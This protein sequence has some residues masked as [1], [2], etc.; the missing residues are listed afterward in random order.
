[1]CSR[2]TWRTSRDRYLALLEFCSGSPYRALTLWL[3]QR[4]MRRA[5]AI[6]NKKMEENI[7]LLRSCRG[8]T[9][10]LLGECNA[11]RLKDTTNSAKRWYVS[12]RLHD[13]T[14]QKTIRM[15]SLVRTVQWT[16]CVLNTVTVRLL[17]CDVSN[18]WNIYSVW[19]K[20]SVLLRGCPVH[21]TKN[22]CA[23]GCLDASIFIY[24]PFCFRRT[25]H[26]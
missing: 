23:L 13:I 26:D 8:W 19:Q 2:E 14:A 5:R 22:V 9:W 1:M 4:D 16:H 12:T 18:V 3:A 7:W 6:G 24:S 15:E 20:S 21:T 17:L 11:A 25:M 10:K